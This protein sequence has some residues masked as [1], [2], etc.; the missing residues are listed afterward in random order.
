MI[1]VKFISDSNEFVHI[2][3]SINLQVSGIKSSFSGKISRLSE[4]KESMK[5]LLVSLECR[6]VSRFLSKRIGEFEGTKFMRGYSYV[7]F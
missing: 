6:D 1:P 3:P 5:Q 7:T 4:I 2:L